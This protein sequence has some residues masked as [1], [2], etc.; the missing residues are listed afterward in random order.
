LIYIRALIV[1][2]D[3]TFAFAELN[4]PPSCR[5]WRESWEYVRC[6]GSTA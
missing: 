3:M 4:R 5:P 1:S 2:T 6:I